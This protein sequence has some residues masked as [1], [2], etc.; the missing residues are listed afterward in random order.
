L[1]VSEYV[2]LVGDI[3]VSGFLGGVAS[4]RCSVWSLIHLPKGDSCWIPLHSKRRVYSAFDRS[5]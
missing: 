1:L 5:W 2:P 4:V 3:F